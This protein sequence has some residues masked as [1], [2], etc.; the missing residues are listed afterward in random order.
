MRRARPP[1]LVACLGCDTPRGMLCFSTE[2]T[3]KVTP[4]ALPPPALPAARRLGPAAATTLS[5]RSL[6]SRR[7][8][9]ARATARQPPRRA[10]HRARSSAASF[11]A[12]PR[13]PPQLGWR[14]RAFAC[15]TKAEP[16]LTVELGLRRTPADSQPADPAPLH[17]RTRHECPS[18]LRPPRN[19]GPPAVR[20]RTATSSPP[21]SRYL[22]WPSR[23]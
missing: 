9:G 14:P 15:D 10:R 13:H 7:P 4:C 18:T 8:S 6:A 20:A 12:R 16:D 5:K 11:P 23:E 22:A 17:P 21:R 1:R 19:L 3:R 2:P